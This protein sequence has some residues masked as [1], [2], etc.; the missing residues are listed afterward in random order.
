MIIKN[1]VLTQRNIL[2]IKYEKNEYNLKPKVII[3]IKCLIIKF[4]CFYIITI[5]LLILFWYY[6]SCFS[7]V[8]KNTQK[9]LFINSLIGILISFIYSFIFCLI[10]GIFRIPSL[11]APEKNLYKISQI[12]QIL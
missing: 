9:H 5:L 8:Y 10:P 12:I 11:K 4:V 3:V 7:I 6:I 1:L 2:E